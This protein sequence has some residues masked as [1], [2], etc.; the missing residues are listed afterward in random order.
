MTTVEWVGLA[1]T[2][3]TAVVNICVL[4]AARHA[5]LADLIVREG[6]RVHAQTAAVTRE[7]RAHLPRRYAAI[8]DRLGREGDVAE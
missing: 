2:V 4:R 7:L 3:V 5:F 1:V 8:S 6:M